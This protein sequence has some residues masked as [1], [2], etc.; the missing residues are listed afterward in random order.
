MNED[1]S[2]KWAFSS[3]YNHISSDSSFS[4]AGIADIMHRDAA[5]IFYALF[6]AGK[7]LFHWNMPFLFM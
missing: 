7:Y 6:L 4:Q 2:R 3:R 1:D 5:V